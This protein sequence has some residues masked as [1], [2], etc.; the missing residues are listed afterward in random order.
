MT[1]TPERKPEFDPRYV[2]LSQLHHRVTLLFR[3]LV[4]AEIIPPDYFPPTRYLGGKA[5]D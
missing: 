3:E 5:D 2:T 4:A 1:D